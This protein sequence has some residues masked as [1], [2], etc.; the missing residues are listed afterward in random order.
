MGEDE[1]RQSVPTQPLTNLLSSS[2]AR[3]L[4]RTSED[5]WR[6][7]FKR[8][9]A[10]YPTIEVSRETSVAYWQSLRRY[11]RGRVARAIERHVE[12]SRF[13]PAI[14]EIV[15]LLNEEGCP[16][17]TWRPT[18]RDCRCGFPDCREIWRGDTCDECGQ[19][20]KR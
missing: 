7:V 5:D 13:F 4:V 8:L 20:K 18:V 1:Q 12:H 17:T 15:A 6:S 16:H 19:E 3:E 10:C 11:S 2:N 9:S 14:S